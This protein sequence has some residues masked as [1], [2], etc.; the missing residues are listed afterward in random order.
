MA[1]QTEKKPAKPGIGATIAKIAF[2][3]MFL[4]VSFSDPGETDRTAFLVVGLAIGLALIAWG[5]LPWLRAAKEEKQLRL[6]TERRREEARL[7]AERKAEKE[8]E[9]RI[10][11]NCGAT[12]RGKVC[13]YCGSKLP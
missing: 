10:C 7:R 12:S 13:E 11:P 1:K 6:E 9:V 4:G 8:N 3:V 5:I 2:G